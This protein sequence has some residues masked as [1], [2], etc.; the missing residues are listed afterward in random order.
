MSGNAPFNLEA[1]AAVVGAFFLDNELVKECTIRPE[2]LY[3]PKLRLLYT[4]IRHLDEKGRPIDPITVCEELGNRNIQ[5]LGGVSYITDLAGSVPTTANFHFYENMVR[6][7]DKKRKAVQIAAKIIESAKNSEINKTLNESIHELMAVDDDKVDEENGDITPALVNLFEECEKDLGD[8]IGIPSGFKHLDRLTGGFQESD[9][10]IVGAR[11]SMGKTAFALNLAMQ[12]AKEDVSLFFSLEMS[13][14]QLLKRI[15]G[16]TARIDSFK[17][18]NPRRE[19]GDDD[20]R[21]FSETLGYL[22]KVNLHIFDKAGMDIPYIWSKVR[23]ARREYKKD[24]RI[25]VIIDYL[26]LIESDSKNNQNRQAEISEISRAIKTM[27]R[28]LN[29]VVIALSQL[30]R[31]VESRFD[32]RPILSDL[33]ESGQI[34]QDADLIAFLYRDDYYDK[35]STQKNMMEI[36]FAKHRNGP[37]GTIELGFNKE[38]GKFVSLV[39]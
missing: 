37:T 13:K 20:W 15:T 29:V 9:L 11:P 4:A 33:R 1:E 39:E 5:R 18:K 24:K 34:E 27:A 10:M 3:S 26:Q 19:F 2:H 23:K 12:A 22:S 28:E 14:K 35:E 36:I 30:S 32:K 17:M 25:L 38:Y 8:I 31:G 7:Y 21:N 16:F 6:E